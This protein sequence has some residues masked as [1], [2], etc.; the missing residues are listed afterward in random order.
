[1]ATQMEGRSVLFCLRLFCSRTRSLCRGH[2]PHQE[3]SRSFCLRYYCLHCPNVCILIPD[4]WG[5]SR[6]S[7]KYSI[8][9]KIYNN[10]DNLYSTKV[11]KVVRRFSKLRKVQYK[12]KGAKNV[13]FKTQAAV[14]YRD[15][16]PLGCAS[17]F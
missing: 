6:L 10:N 5:R 9:L 14:F 1:M 7:C 16:K 11:Q 3:V 2:I 8:Y 13:M 15:L 12:S 17:W 4:L